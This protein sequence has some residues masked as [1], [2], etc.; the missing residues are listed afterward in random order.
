MAVSVAV[1]VAFPK[2]ILPVPLGVMFISLFDVETM[3][4]VTTSKFPPSCG[5]VSPERL[6]DESETLTVFA[7][8]SNVAK[9]MSSE[10]SKN[11]NIGADALEVSSQNVPLTALDGLD[12][13]E[14]DV[15]IAPNTVFKSLLNDGND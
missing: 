12:E 1:T 15:L 4:Y 5:L 6:V 3:L 13:P 10:P 11:F 14:F 2:T 9:V 8:V 7:L